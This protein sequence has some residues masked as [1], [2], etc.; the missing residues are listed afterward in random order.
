MKPYFET[1]HAAGIVI[2]IVTLVWGAME[3]AQFSQGLEARK[4]AAKVTR[5][6]WR[7]AACTCLIGVNVALYGAPRILPAAAIR[8]APVSFAAGLVVL[9]AGQTLRGWSFKTLGD[10]FTFTVM[11]STDQPVVTAG[12]YRL[13]RHPSYS[14]LLLACAGVGLMAANWAGLIAVIMLPLALILWRI[15]IEEQALMATIGDRHR[16]YSSGHKRL[17]PLV[18]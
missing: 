2:L 4:G 6:Y 17:V 10:Y 8:P 14:G 7:L 11:V 3:T 9:L 12:P 16:S 5:R 1:N 13:L 18:W 15:Q